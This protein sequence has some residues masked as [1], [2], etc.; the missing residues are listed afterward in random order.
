MVG[1]PDQDIIGVKES[2]LAVKDLGAKPR[3]S[4]FSPIPG[5]AD[6][7]EIVSRGYLDEDSDPLLHNKLVFPYVWGNITPEEFLSLKRLI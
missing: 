3:L 5:T 1:L 2:I 4:Y 6:C 7:E